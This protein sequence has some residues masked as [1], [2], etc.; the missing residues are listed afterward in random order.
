MVFDRTPYIKY[1][2]VWLDEQLMWDTHI[3]QLTK[4]V[5]GLIGIL[6]RK[7]YLLPMF[8]RK[9][10][11][12]A[13]V[14]S[15]LIYCIEVYGK[16]RKSVLNPLIV[17]CNL[18]LRILQDKPRTHNVKELYKQ[19]DTLPVNLLYKLFILKLMYRV[20]YCRSCLPNVISNLFIINDNIHSHNTRS[21]HEFNIQANSCVNSISF[22][23]PS[24]WFKLPR[25]NREYS[26]VLEFV[27]ECK[28]YLLNEF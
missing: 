23:G 20:V 12:F 17:K 26:S 4:K 24:L 10:I 11:Y 27:S 15:S 9:N 5:N 18:L 2:N 25:I 14:Y 3:A 19:Y 21:R 13:L 7:K 28:I 16:A 22:I 1:L 6:Y 8:C